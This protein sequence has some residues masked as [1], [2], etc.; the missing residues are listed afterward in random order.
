MD[1]GTNGWMKKASR[2]RRPLLYVIPV[3]FP[4]IQK[5]PGYLGERKSEMPGEG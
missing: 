4:V 3:N 5:T 1:D 2:P